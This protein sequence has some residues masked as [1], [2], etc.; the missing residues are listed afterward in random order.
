MASFRFFRLRSFIPPFS[1]GASSCGR[2]SLGVCPSS[3]QMNFRNSFVN[4][5]RIGAGMPCALVKNCVRPPTIAWAISR[6][7]SKVGRTVFQRS[8]SRLTRSMIGSHGLVSCV[9]FPIQAPR[10]RTDSPSC[11]MCTSAC[12]GV[13]AGLS[14]RDCITLSRCAFV[15]IGIISVFS[16][17]NFA[18]DAWHHLSSVLMTSS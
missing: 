9:S 1:T 13:S 15:P 4:A 18:P 11:A 5:S 6:F 12:I 17:L 2:P 14:L 10:E 16:L 7:P 8:R 3:S